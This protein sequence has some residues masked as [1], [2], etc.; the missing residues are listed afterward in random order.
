MQKCPTCGAALEVEIKPGV[1]LKPADLVEPGKDNT[2]E[3]INEITT[4]F[5][6]EQ[7]EAVSLLEIR[8]GLNHIIVKPKAWIKNRDVVKGIFNVLAR[9]GAEYKSEG[10]NTHWE[11]PL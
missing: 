5:Q 8:P 1:E 9:F 4:A 6:N 3:K 2:Q 11:V 7:P 10:A